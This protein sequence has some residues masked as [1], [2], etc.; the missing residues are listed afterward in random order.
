MSYQ[1][2][3]HDEKLPI[4]EMVGG[5]LFSRLGRIPR[6]GDDYIHE[7]VTFSVLDADERQVTR[8]RV[9]VAE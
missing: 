6:R 5:F 7:N 1:I 9:L 8:M 2:Y 4:K 3:L